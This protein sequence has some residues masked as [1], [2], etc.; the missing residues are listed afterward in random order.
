[1]AGE[2]GREVACVGVGREEA[3]GPP[4]AMTG[5]EVAD[6]VLDLMG[7]DVNDEFPAVRDTTLWPGSPVAHPP[8]P[9]VGRGERQ[10]FR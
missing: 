9:T 7:G 1:M 10:A 6:G 8:V 2:L 5:A 3:Y 4:A